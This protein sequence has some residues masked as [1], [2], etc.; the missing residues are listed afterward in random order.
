[1]DTKRTSV[2]QFESKTVLLII[3]IDRMICKKIDYMKRAGH[4][5]R[6]DYG[7]RERAL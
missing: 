6:A 7:T 1:M 5:K 3:P 4:V 2:A